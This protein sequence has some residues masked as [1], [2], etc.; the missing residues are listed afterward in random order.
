MRGQSHG[1]EVKGAVIAALLAGQS[2]SEVADDY[3]I[4]PK[5]VRDW[6]KKAGIEPGS[7]TS[8]Q[9]PPQKRDELGDIITDNLRKNF[10]A[11]SAIADHVGDKD[12]LNKQSAADLAVLYGV[13]SDKGFRTIAS[14]DLGSDDDPAGEGD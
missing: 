7:P 2:V 11:L 8:P 9:V 13:F 10:I 14:L 6:R 12:W 4:A 5:T 3:K 1:N